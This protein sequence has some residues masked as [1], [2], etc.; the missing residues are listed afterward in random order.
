MPTATVLTK[1]R[2]TLPANVRQALDIEK[3]DRVAFA[4]V[5]PGRFEI[6]AATRPVTALKGMFGKAKRTV[7]VEEMH[8]AI[9]SKGASAR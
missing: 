3:G 9:V 6:V 8:F 7:S 4:E 2:I 1:R 5:E